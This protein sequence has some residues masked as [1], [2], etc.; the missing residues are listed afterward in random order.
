MVEICKKTYHFRAAGALPQTAEDTIGRNPC[1]RSSSTVVNNHYAVQCKIQSCCTHTIFFKFK[2]WH[3]I[4]SFENRK[5]PDRAY[6]TDWWVRSGAD[7]VDTTSKVDS[8]NEKS[9]LG[10]VIPRGFCRVP[11]HFYSDCGAPKTPGGLVLVFF[12][13]RKMENTAGTRFFLKKLFLT[14]ICAEAT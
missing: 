2:I 7:W 9:K 3:D 5:M 4:G 10:L 12:E 11:D 1:V 13:T 8:Q 6:P 14:L